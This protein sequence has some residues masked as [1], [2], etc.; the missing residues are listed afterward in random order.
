MALTTRT[1]TAPPRTPMWTIERVHVNAF[2]ITPE[3]SHLDL[4]SLLSRTVAASANGVEQ[5][6]CTV[7]GA[8]EYGFQRENVARSLAFGAASH[9]TT[10]D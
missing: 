10:Q 4:D 8:A 1:A 5:F 6:S 2:R 9:M 7:T 3:A